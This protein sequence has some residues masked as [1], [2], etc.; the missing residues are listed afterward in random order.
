MKIILIYKYFTELFFKKLE[1]I[2]NIFFLV[3]GI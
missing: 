3:V 1:I 2:L